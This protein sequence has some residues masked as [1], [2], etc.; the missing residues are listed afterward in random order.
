MNDRAVVVERSRASIICSSLLKVEGSNPAIS[1]FFEREIVRQEHNLNFRKTGVIMKST[2]D[3]TR[4]D[5]D[6]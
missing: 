5:R 6:N 3:I 1:V 4:E 2:H